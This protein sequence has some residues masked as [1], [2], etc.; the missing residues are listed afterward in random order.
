M[1]QNIWNLTKSSKA[2][3]QGVWMPIARAINDGR[4]EMGPHKL[5]EL[6]KAAQLIDFK[7]GHI[8]ELGV[9]KGGSA[10]VIANVFKPKPAWTSVPR[11][12]YLFDTFSGMPED[13][14]LEAGLGVREGKLRDISHRKGDFSSTSEQDVK[15]YL[16][17]LYPSCVFLSGVFPETAEAV[18]DEEFC[19]V[20]L[21]ADIYQSTKAGIEFFYPRLVKGG[22]IFFDDYSE[23]LV[24]GC[25]GVQK[26]IN[27]YFE[28]KDV[29]VVRKPSPG[30][31]Y[32]KKA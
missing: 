24:Q 4:T 31:A 19:F 29:S 21:D 28:D 16:S 14:E 27:E 20:H 12:F 18:K 30:I 10:A 9:Y 32:V 26:A 11:N 25:P 17:A 1:D 8:A 13:D 6:S 15:N 22:V 3:G 2:G 23:E 7:G 5:L